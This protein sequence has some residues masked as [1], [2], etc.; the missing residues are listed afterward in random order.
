MSIPALT[1]S[2]PSKEQDFKSLLNNN[3]GWERSQSAREGGKEGTASG[4]QSR[5]KRKLGRKRESKGV[6]GGR[7]AEGD[8]S[9]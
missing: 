7:M 1:R 9:R 3:Q 2:S 5:R 8:T 6:G 4:N